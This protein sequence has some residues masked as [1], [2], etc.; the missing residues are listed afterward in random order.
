MAVAAAPHQVMIVAHPL[1]GVAQREIL[2]L[3]GLPKTPI[4]LQLLRT[5]TAAAAAA[6]AH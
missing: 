5:M 2:L 1:V 6:A 4:Q 3:A